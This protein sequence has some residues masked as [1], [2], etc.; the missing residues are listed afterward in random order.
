LSQVININTKVLL[1][2]L[3]ETV[4]IFLIG[5][6]WGF[7]NCQD[8]GYLI[9]TIVVSGTIWVLLAKG[10]GY[11]ADYISSKVNWLE[12]PLKR[13]VLGLLGHVVYTILAVVAL[14]YVLDIFFD[15]KLGGLE[16]TLKISVGITLAITIILTSR[17]FL[18]SWR[19]VAVDHEKVKKEVANAKYESLRNQVNPHFLFNS[20]NVLTDLVYEDQ[21]MAA[22]FIKKLSDVYRYVLDVRDKELI[23]LQEEFNFIESYVFLLKIRHGE[24][25]KFSNNIQAEEGE[26]VAPMSLQMLIENCIKHNVVSEDDPLYI[27]IERADGYIRVSNNLQIRKNPTQNETGVG[28]KNIQSRYKFLSDKP[29]IVSKEEDKFAVNIPVIMS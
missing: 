17:E 7:Y 8:C 11:V 24:A 28:L 13:M 12:A 21:D 15:I 6:P 4:I 19:Q 18:L 22:K 26:Q 3:K 2:E 9:S 20:F 23:T 1:K 25:L 16:G 10:N 5:V 29:V 14:Y 27:Q